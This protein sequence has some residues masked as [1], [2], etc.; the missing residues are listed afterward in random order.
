MMYVWYVAQTQ[1]LT[2]THGSKLICVYV[3]YMPSIICSASLTTLLIIIIII[4]Y[5]I[6]MVFIQCLLLACI[7]SAV[8]WCVHAV[9]PQ[10]LVYVLCR[11]SC[12]LSS[13]P[14]SPSDV[15]INDGFCILPI[16]THLWSNCE[17]RWWKC[18]VSDFNTGA[19]S[20]PYNY[21]T[22]IDH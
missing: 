19:G 9:L 7:V 16:S 8:L 18:Y 20:E 15:W 21:R 10:S 14:K 11:W 12:W 17:W 5:V 13:G 3:V 22:T 1:T 4:I 2:L 6:S